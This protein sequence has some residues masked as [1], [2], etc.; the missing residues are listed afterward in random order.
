MQCGD[1][2]GGRGALAA[3]SSL[4]KTVVVGARCSP[5]VADGVVNLVVVADVFAAQLMILI[6]R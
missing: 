6:R 1:R 2:S 3:H 5:G 4:Y